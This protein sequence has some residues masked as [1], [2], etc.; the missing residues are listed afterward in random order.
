MPPDGL[1]WPSVALTILNTLGSIRQPV[2]RHLDD[3]GS[4]I[5]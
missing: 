5:V 1:L 2:L 3:G 4:I